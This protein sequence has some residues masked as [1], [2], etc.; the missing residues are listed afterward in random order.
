[1]KMNSLD[2]LHLLVEKLNEE[3]PLELSAYFP[4]SYTELLQGR[5]AAELGGEPI[6]SM[7]HFQRT[8]ALPPSLVQQVTLS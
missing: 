2:A 1:M 8:G 3:R 7:R 5:T 4:K 6:L